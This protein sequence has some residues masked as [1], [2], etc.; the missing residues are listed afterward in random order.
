MCNAVMIQFPWIESVPLDWISCF[1]W[2]EVTFMNTVSYWPETF[3][4][5]WTDTSSLGWKCFYMLKTINPQKC[6][7]GNALLWFEWSVTSSSWYVEAFCMLDVKCGIN[8]TFE[9]L[10]HNICWQSLVSFY[11]FLNFFLLIYFS[12][13]SISSLLSPAQAFETNSTARWGV[14]DGRHAGAPHSRRPRGSHRLDGRSAP[15]ACRRSHLSHYLPAH[16][17]GH[18]HRPSRYAPIG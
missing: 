3:C 2:K 10:E 7:R 6:Q 8:F 1:T 9:Q 11:A 17:Q 5:I 15:A 18:T 4:W 12:F 16:L 13:L 14:R